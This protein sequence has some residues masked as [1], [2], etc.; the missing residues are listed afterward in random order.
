M[1]TLV[2]ARLAVPRS[3]DI[4]VAV[5][6]DERLGPRFD[7][8]PSHQRQV[9]ARR[10][11][12]D[13]QPFRIGVEQRRPAFA[14]PVERILHVGDQL[15]QLSLR[16]EAIVDRYEDRQPLFTSLSAQTPTASRLP[17]IKAPP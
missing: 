16:S 6:G 13:R 1:V 17:V 12:Q 2:R 15:R 9:A 7:P 5:Q 4:A 11:A 8:I 10:A 3:D 14:D